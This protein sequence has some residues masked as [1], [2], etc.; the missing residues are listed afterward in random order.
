MAALDYAALSAAIV[1]AEKRVR[2]LRGL[3]A[4]GLQDSMNKKLK[5]LDAS[6][7]DYIAAMRTGLNTIARLESVG[8]PTAPSVTL[9]VDEM[10][11]LKDALDAFMEAQGGLLQIDPAVTGRILLGEKGDK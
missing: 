3:L 9:D 5:D 1:K 8:F 2:G 10:K 6:L 11:N 7:V 4:L